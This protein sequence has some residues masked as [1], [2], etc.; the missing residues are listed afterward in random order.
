MAGKQFSM[1]PKTVPHIKT[2]FRRIVTP[3]PVPESLPILEKLR[4]YEPVSMSGQALVV[5]DKAEGVQVYER[6][7]HQVLRKPATEEHIMVF[8]HT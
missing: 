5:W 8:F 2:K 4:N 6:P 7:V 3:L 1:E